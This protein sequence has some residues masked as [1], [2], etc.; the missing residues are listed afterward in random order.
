MDPEQSIDGYLAELRTAGPNPPEALRRAILELGPAAVPSLIAMASDPA[1]YEVAED[2][3]DGR[4]GWAPYTA[5]EILGD[6]HPPE[7]LEPLI[8]LL[9][10]DEYD[11]LLERVLE[12]LGKFGRPAFDALAAIAADT[13]VEESGC[14]S[15]RC[16]DSGQSCRMSRA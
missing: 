1:E 13:A 8:A 6:M 10:W 11:E 14:A 15:M 16:M 3:V 7:A 2:D 4:T 12:A 9:S 5:V